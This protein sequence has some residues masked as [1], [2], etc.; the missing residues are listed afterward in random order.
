MD[1]R[2]LPLLLALPALCD[3]L[4]CRGYGASWR[5]VRARLGLCGCRPGD[6]LTALGLVLAGLGLGVL[7]LTWLSPAQRGL[8]GGALRLDQGPPPPSLALWLLRCAWLALGLELFLRVWAGGLLVR[9]LGFR[10]GN[11]LQ[12]LASALVVLLLLPPGALLWGLLVW[13]GLAWALGWLLW[14][15]GSLLPGWLAGALLLALALLL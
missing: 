14:R 8:L 5:E 4:L 10:R 15:S 12:A 9:A 11:A 6:L 1:Q 3:A 7:A 13:C 2:L